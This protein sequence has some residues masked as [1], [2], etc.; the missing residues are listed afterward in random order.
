MGSNVR[1]VGIV[2]GDSGDGG[3]AETRQV[4]RRGGGDEGQGFD[5]IARI[6]LYYFICHRQ[7]QAI[8]QIFYSTSHFTMLMLLIHT[9]TPCVD[10]SPYCSNQMCSLML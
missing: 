8:P 2:C 5:V 3:D 4:S 7:L 9:Y 10:Y 6:L 1:I